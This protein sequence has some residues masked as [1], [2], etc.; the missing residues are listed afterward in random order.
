MRS[1]ALRSARFKPSRNLWLF[2]G[3]SF[4]TDVSSHMVLPLL[5]LFLV[6]VLRATPS[7]VGLVEGGAESFAALIKGF[8]GRWSDRSGQRRLFV[9][10]GYALSTL[11]RALFVIATSWPLVLL[12]RL[13]ERI[14][15][16]LRSAPRDAL[17]VEDTEPAFRGRAFGFQQA[18]DAAGALLGA[19]LVWWLVA[20]FSYRELFT[21][22]LLPA[23]IGVMLALLVREKGGQKGGQVGISQAKSQP[24]PLFPK[25]QPAPLFPRARFRDLPP[26]LGR[27]IVA[28]ALFALG[29]FGVAFF[30][31]AASARGLGDRDTLAFY[32]VFN[33]AGTLAAWPAGRW[34]DTHGRRPLLV[35]GYTLFT[36]ACIAMLV[37]VT[38]SWV[39]AFAL[40][41]AGV[42]VIDAVQ[43][44]LIADLAPPHLRA[45]AMG[46]YY[47]AIALVALPGGWLAGKLWQVYSPDA[48]FVFGIVT[49][50]VAAWMIWRLPESHTAR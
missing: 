48:T 19:V 15:K 12:A 27:A 9:V 26:A 3:T 18:F 1:D 46:A 35:G 39:I 24:D 40:L 20:Y 21:I 32:I 2:A 45:T 10:S 37:H 13:T 11:T 23:A 49:S 6:G 8:A 31:L 17:I 47:A 34:S 4:F 42:A 36:A 25:S 16:G 33:A 28:C 38:T 43:R 50:I 7:I 14:G 5:P 22:A 30:V 41:G 29:Q 44:A